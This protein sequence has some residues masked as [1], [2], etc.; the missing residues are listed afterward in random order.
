VEEARILLIEDDTDLAEML[1]R[2]FRL[3]GHELEV[4]H[5]G[6]QGVAM[7]TAERPDLVL[8]DIRLPD[9]SGYEVCT[10]LRE[11]RKTA[12]IPVI[13][14]TERREREERLAGL[15]LGAV[16]YITKPFD[17]QE[18]RLRVRNVLRRARRQPLLNGVTGLPEGDMVQENLEAALAEGGWGMVVTSVGG[19]RAFRD[20]YGFVAADDAARAI[21]LMLKNAL[22]ESGDGDAF[23]GHLGPH[24]FVVL[25]GAD[26]S[27]PVADACFRRLDSAVQYFY[28]ETDRETAL[29]RPEQDRLHVRTASL[30]AAEGSFTT[31]KEL[32]EALL[33]LVR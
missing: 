15:A 12:D 24:D 2:F 7:A 1:V 9:I 26:R 33:A 13:F 23:I 32:R 18:L 30:T 11:Q 20:S 8:L 3:H 21:S 5:W 19:L 29:A 27:T 28:P 22:R 17:V 31:L 16:D 6:E 14:L 4:A 10:R 25:T